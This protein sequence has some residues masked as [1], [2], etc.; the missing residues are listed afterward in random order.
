MISLNKARESFKKASEKYHAEM[1]SESQA[2]RKEL[3]NLTAELASYPH[4]FPHLRLWMVDVR[5]KTE[6]NEE[7]I[8]KI[9]DEFL[10]ADLDDPT[11]ALEKHN[12]LIGGNMRQQVLDL[13]ETN[14][15]YMTDSGAGQGGWHIGC[16]CTNYEA[17]A[18]CGLLHATFAKA[19]KSSYITIIRRYWSPS[20]KD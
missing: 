2:T 16:H 14:E 19:I 10:H 13:I 3:D 17:D 20:W 7:S 12:S 11:D 15:F 4:I 18:L 6:M 8:H 9:N 1:F 5:G